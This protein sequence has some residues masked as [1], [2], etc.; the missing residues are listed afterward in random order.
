[1]TILMPLSTGV[2]CAGG[3]S[4][5]TVKEPTGASVAYGAPEQTSYRVEADPQREKLRL[6][7]YESSLC[8]VIPVTIV[9]RYQVVYRGEKEVSRSPLNKGQV[10]GDPTKTVPCRQTWARNVE[11][12]LELGDSRFSLGKT[13]AG[14][15]VTAD[16]AKL[17]DTGN[18]EL[19]DKSAK[20]ILRL[21]QGR[22]PVTIGEVA[23]GD[24]AQRQAKV[25]ELIQSLEAILAKGETGASPEEISSSYKLYGQLIDL[26]GDDPR[27]QGLAARFRELTIGRKKEEARVRLEKNLQALSGAQELLKNAG[28]AAIPLY[29]QAAVSSGTM[30]RRALEW[31]SLQIMGAIRG[32]SLICQ[33]GF[34]FQG[35][36]SYG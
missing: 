1:M 36:R 23:L 27:V 32:S 34:S 8:D 7:V 20:V 31:S 3:T 26:A 11:V 16:L 14:G 33:Q 2:A 17:F 4:V 9:Q 24:L 28:D 15:Q 13:N 10:A 12:M 30:D 19:T 6:T 25:D 18:Y 21:N 35:V 22:P 5:R 29:V